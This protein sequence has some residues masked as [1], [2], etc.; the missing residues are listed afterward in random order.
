MANIPGTPIWEDFIEG[1]VNK[2]T[3]G[4]TGLNGLLQTIANR[5]QFLK[6]KQDELSSSYV[7]EIGNN[8]NGYYRKWSDGYIE[9]WRRL[10]AS[11]A[12]KTVL[13]FPVPFTDV[14]SIVIVATEATISS[15]PLGGVNAVGTAYDTYTTTTFMA[16]VANSPENF[17][18]VARGY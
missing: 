4:F 13:T 14:N 8:A 15:G 16:R 10:P 9:Q 2:V 7:T 6:D 17:S 18:Y 5:L 3:N 1:V 11:I 12:D